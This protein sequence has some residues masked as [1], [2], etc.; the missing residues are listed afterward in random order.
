VLK[1]TFNPRNGQWAAPAPATLHTAAKNGKKPAVVAL[2]KQSLETLL[3]TLAEM[4]FT[5]EQSSAAL[6]ANGNDLS[7]A[8]A[9]LIQAGGP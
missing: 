8:V 1:L 9:S 3:Y 7:S 6:K 2:E 5:E 4:G